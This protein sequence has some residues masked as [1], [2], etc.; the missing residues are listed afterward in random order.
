VLAEVGVEVAAV[1]SRQQL[2]IGVQTPLEI[3]YAVFCASQ[4]VQAPTPSSF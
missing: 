1:R 2:A 3:V 4:P